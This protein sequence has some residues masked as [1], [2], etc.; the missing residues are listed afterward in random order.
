MVSGSRR[1]VILVAVALSLVVGRGVR[2]G[3]P[4]P[5]TV[6]TLPVV[7][8]ALE[9]GSTE[10]QTRRVVYAPPPGWY[11][12]SHRVV[13]TK[14]HGLSSYTV[15]TVPAGWGWSSDE[16]ATEASKARAAVAGAVHEVRFG[17]QAGV[18]TDQSAAGRQNVSASH[19]ALVVEVLARGAGFLRG[20]A[21][22]ELTVQAE[23]VYLGTP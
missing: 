21:G 18:E 15:N 17:G 14:K 16:E 11:V 13:C 22:V 19:H 23:L 20:G 10:K 9:V 12:R 3:E 1:P 4:S 7:S 2:A 6:K 5:G 8:V